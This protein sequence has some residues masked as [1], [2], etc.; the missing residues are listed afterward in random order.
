M[1]QPLPLHRMAVPPRC[2]W[3]WPRARPRVGC[4]SVPRPVRQELRTRAAPEPSSEPS[5]SSAL[6]KSRQY[7]RTVAKGTPPAERKPGSDVG[8]QCSTDQSRRKH[9][10]VVP[11]KRSLR[12]REPV[13]SEV[14]GDLGALIRAGASRA[15]SRDRRAALCEPHHCA[16]T[17]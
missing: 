15:Q 10:A 7:N 1:R 14:K 8:N 5:A 17:L 11:S 16:S 6:L 2:W 4:P 9:L 13:L 3:R 12:K